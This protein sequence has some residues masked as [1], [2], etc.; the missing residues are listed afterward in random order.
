VIRD[1][2]G[3]PKIDGNK[4]DRTVRKIYKGE[5]QF[6]AKEHYM[7]VTPRGA[8]YYAWEDDMTV[9]ASRSPSTRDNEDERAKTDIEEIKA[10]DSEDQ[11]QTVTHSPERHP[12]L[13]GW[14]PIYAQIEKE[15][16]NYEFRSRHEQFMM[17]LDH[18]FYVPNSCFEGYDIPIDCSFYEA[19][20]AGRPRNSTP[21][22]IWYE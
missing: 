7:G 5:E 11:D 22:E 14:T 21:P 13:I 17:H 20:V 1:M 19:P 15:D 9:V 10:R 16:A 18:K 3:N 12:V 8:D 4:V 2:R 6:V